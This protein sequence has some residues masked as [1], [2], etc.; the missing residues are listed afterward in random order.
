MTD[1]NFVK[2]LSFLDR[3]A[4]SGGIA[5]LRERCRV[6][7]FVINSLNGPSGFYWYQLHDLL[8]GDDIKAAVIHIAI[9]GKLITAVDVSRGDRSANTLTDYSALL[10]LIDCTTDHWRES[11]RLDRFSGGVVR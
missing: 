8:D 9:A 4:V 11:R 2:A 3:A 10:N 1:T 6:V 7:A 5:D